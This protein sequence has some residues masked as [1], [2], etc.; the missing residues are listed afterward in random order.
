MYHTLWQYSDRNS[1]I[2]GKIALFG[3]YLALGSITGSVECRQKFLLSTTFIAPSVSIRLYRTMCMHSADYA[4]AIIGK[5]SVCPSVRH[6]PVFCWN[7]T[8]I[9]KL[10]SPPQILVFPHQT[11]LQ[12]SDGYSLNGGVECKGVWKNCDFRPIS[13]YVFETIQDTAIVTIECE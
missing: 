12:Y 11:V 7:I 2:G 3:Q 5:L 8:H 1:L 10:F 6:M 9:L 4:M 13:R